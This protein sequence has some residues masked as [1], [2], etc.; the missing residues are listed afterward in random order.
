MNAFLG[1]LFTRPNILGETFG[2]LQ[3]IFWLMIFLITNSTK[4][5]EANG[6]SKK[7]TLQKALAKIYIPILTF[8]FVFWI[9]VSI[10]DAAR[11]GS[12]SIWVVFSNT[13]GLV[14]AIAALTRLLTEDYSII[15]ARVFVFFVLLPSIGNLLNVLFSQIFPCTQVNFANFGGRDWVY[16]ICSSGSVYL[17]DRFTG[18][19]GEPGIFATEIALAVFLLLSTRVYSKKINIIIIPILVFGCFSTLSTTGYF[20]LT[21]ALISV[22]YNKSHINSLT[23][24]YLFALSI[25]PISAFSSKLLKQKALN[26][27]ASISDR[28]AFDS[29]EDYIYSWSNYFFGNTSFQT[30]Q[31]PGINLLSLSLYYGFPIII[32]SFL[33]IVRIV[34]NLR[35]DLRLNGVLWITVFTMLFSQPPVTNYLWLIVFYLATSVIMVQHKTRK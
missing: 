26:N 32:L 25:L 3:P 28:F 1:L 33:F 14:T 27:P 9:Y 8:Y 13:I 30:S 19:G 22:L 23:G 31:N 35:S 18:F 7:K 2:Y 16:S 10:I 12:I 15:L 11:F 24:F 21:I 20:A 17:D 34:I 5:N 29:T 6:V 4:L